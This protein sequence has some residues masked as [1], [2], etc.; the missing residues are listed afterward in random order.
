MG[1]L[2]IVNLRSIH[3]ESARGMRWSQQLL[4]SWA[5]L[6]SHCHSDSHW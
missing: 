4:T 6:G 1:A 2:H 5:L 3:D